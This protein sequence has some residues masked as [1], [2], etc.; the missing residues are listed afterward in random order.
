MTLSKSNH[1]FF[2]CFVLGGG[3]GGV[4]L[5][6]GCFL[7]VVLFHTVSHELHNTE[8]HN[9]KQFTELCLIKFFEKLDLVLLGPS[10][11]K[12]IINI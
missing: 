6:L 7:P 3:G 11:D 10:E 2:F 1:R 4:L 12:G 8:Q 5:A 9:R